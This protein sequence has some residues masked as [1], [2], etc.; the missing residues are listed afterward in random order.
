MGE[1]ERILEAPHLK[2]IFLVVV[3]AFVVIQFFIKLWDFFRDRFEIETKSTRRE[4]T[5]SE[6]I[7]NMKN[8]IDSIKQDQKEIKSCLNSLQ[9]AVDTLQQRSDKNEAARIKDR[10]SQ[11]YRFFSAKGEW[12]SM[13]KE[14]FMDLI[15][16]YSQYSSNSFVH[17]IIEPEMLKW[18]VVD[19]KEE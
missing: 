1:L 18:K 9:M 7:S 2:E 10:L 13:D 17:T 5:Q 11:G 15:D 6:T 14:S 19:I 8:E 3:A 12:T 16:S 4:K